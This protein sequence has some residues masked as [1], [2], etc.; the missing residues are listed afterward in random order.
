MSKSR[1]GS[2]RSFDRDEGRRETQ[3][4]NADAVGLDAVDDPQS[5]G[6]RRALLHT[7]LLPV[8]VLATLAAYQPVWHVGML[9]DDEAHITQPSLQSVE[10][11]RRI[12]FNPGASQQYYPL[13]HTA[14]WLQHRLWGTDTL[15]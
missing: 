3:R 1:R 7:L 9:W 12:W 15:G 4:A 8:L 13:V 14:F 5:A 2:G 6:P 11:L 10:G